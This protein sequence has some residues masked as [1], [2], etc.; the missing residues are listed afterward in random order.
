[1]TLAEKLEKLGDQVGKEIPGHPRGMDL[2]RRFIN[3]LELSNKVRFSVETNKDI[4]VFLS[5]MRIRKILVTD[6]PWTHPV[7]G[8][9]GRREA[10]IALL[11]WELQN[12]TSL[13]EIGSL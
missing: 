12:F 6:V 3:S 5:P 9:I 7:K 1:M 10:A 13:R 8:K 4:T 11:R 2:L